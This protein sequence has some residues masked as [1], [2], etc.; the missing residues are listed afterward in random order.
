VP[1]GLHQRWPVEP[2]LVFRAVRG[3]HD[4]LGGDPGKAPTERG[5]L[6][7]LDG[8]ALA[9]LDDMIGPQHGFAGGAC[10]EKVARLPEAE[11]DAQ[12]LG[13]AAQEADAVARQV[14]VERCGKLLAD[15]AGRQCRRGARIGRITLDH[16]DCAGEVWI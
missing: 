4:A 12:K 14:D 15:R 2:A 3:Q 6:E 7:Q 10:Q 13:R 8:A 11:I 9:L 5:R 1:E 16:G